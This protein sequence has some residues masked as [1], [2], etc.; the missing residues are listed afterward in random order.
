MFLIFAPSQGHTSCLLAWSVLLYQPI[1]VPN[2]VSKKNYTMQIQKYNTKT[3]GEALHWK[4]HSSSP[5]S[6]VGVMAV[7]GN[8]SSLLFSTRA[9]QTSP[10]CRNRV[11]ER[12]VPSLKG[13]DKNEPTDMFP[14]E[15]NVRMDKMIVLDNRVVTIIEISKLIPCFGMKMNLI[16]SF[17]D[18]LRADSKMARNEVYSYHSKHRLNSELTCNAESDL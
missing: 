18:P 12:L 10:V 15:I 8:K 6:Y 14:S 11:R 4:L 16:C 3:F 1:V 2:A 9:C 13:L 17:Q 5:M 7:T